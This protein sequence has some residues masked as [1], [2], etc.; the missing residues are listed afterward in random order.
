MPEFFEVQ[1]L[2]KVAVDRSIQ[3][4]KHAEKLIERILF[5][6]G[7]PVV[8]QLNKISI[9]ADVPKQLANDVKLEYG[10]IKSYNA[11]VKLA[12]Q[13][14]D[15]ATKDILEEILQD[16]DGHIDRLESLHAQVEQMGLKI[17]LTTQV[18]E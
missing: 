11:A 2:V 16:E 4:M 12:A 1:E 10:A 7:K 6:E 15:N 8:S 3:E 18:E 13:V 9:G 14:G 5:L 17:F